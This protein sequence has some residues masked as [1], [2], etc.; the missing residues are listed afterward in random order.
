MNSTWAE[1]AK[2]IRKELKKEFPFTKFSVKSDAFSGG[3]SVDVRWIDGPTT[4]SVKGIVDKYQY[5]HFDGMIDLYEYSNR[6]DDIPQVKYV[7][8]SRG[9]SPEVCERMKSELGR[10][11]GVDMNN[12][13]EVFEK[14]RAYPDMLIYRELQGMVFKE[15]SFNE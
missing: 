7:Q 11:F 13:S 6:R 8:T 2:C 1:A 3:T 4:D 5:G 9:F 12:D 14:F 10:K 15:D